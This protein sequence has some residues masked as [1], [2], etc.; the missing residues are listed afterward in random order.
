MLQIKNEMNRLADVNI[1]KPGKH[2]LTP[3]K[4]SGVINY[5]F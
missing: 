3:S 1:Q 2:L 5:H 4:G